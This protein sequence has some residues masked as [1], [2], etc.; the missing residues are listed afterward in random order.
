ML[1]RWIIQS[2]SRKK[3]KSYG[4]P[5]GKFAPVPL[6]LLDN[7][8]YRALGS[9]AQ[10]LLT[11]FLLEWK[12]KN[13]NNNGKIMMSVRQAAEKISVTRDTAA[14]AIRDLQAKGFIVGRKGGSLGI[15]GHG[16]CP[17]YEITSIATPTGPA[18]HLYKEWSEG[19]DFTVFKHAVKNSKGKNKSLS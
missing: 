4:D 19:N 18:S 14:K 11:W 12:G 7:D 13:Y 2:M 5:Q 10:A 3:K 8:A 17:E 9:A 6:S 15:E 16:K 1:L